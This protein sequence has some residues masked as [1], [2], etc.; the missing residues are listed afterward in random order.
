VLVRVVETVVREVAGAG[1]GPKV[2]V[3]GWGVATSRPR[4]RRPPPILSIVYTALLFQVL[5]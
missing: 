3:K 2:A 5:M 1:E 4:L